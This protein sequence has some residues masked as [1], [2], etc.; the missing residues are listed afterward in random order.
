MCVA[1]ESEKMRNLGRS[2]PFAQVWVGDVLQQFVEE[3]FSPAAGLHRQTSEGG[4][5]P[6]C[7]FVLRQEFC[8]TLS[9]LQL[10][11]Y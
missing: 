9:V 11:L 2:A 5:G 4:I 8:I 3:V 10:A 6:V 1:L 7:V